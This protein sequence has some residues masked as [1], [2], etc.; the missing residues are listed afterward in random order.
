MLAVAAPFASDWS[1]VVASVV[2]LWRLSSFSATASVSEAIVDSHAETT[3][4]LDASTPEVL[5]GKNN[6]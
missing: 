4:M 3:P 1:V 5:S 2:D 6:D